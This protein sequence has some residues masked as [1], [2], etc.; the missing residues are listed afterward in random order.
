MKN[1]FRLGFAA[2]ALALF[3]N[4]FA[5]T[6][7]KAQGINEILKKM[8]EHNKALRTLQ[9]NVKMEKV[10][11]QLGESDLYEG[12]TKYLTMKGQDPL[13]RIDWVKPLEESLSVVK[14]QYILYRPR[15]KQ[16]MKGSVNE[17]SKTQ[18]TSNAFAFINMSREQLKANYSVRYLGQE[19][20]SGGIPTWRLELTPKTATSYKMA[21][22]WV[23]GNGMPIQA[24]VTEN[25]KDT[26][27]VLLYNLKKNDVINTSV[28]TIKP[29]AGTKEIKG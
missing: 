25:N 22:L 17:K 19:T 7:I 12:T 15:L 9:A 16:F 11:A 14:K 10:N 5:V 27:T 28:F 6:E 3:F 13:V 23:D 29:P 4:A 21:E 18:G 24:R 8:D 20:V 26:T 1:Y 2:I